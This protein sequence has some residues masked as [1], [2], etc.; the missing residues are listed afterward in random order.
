[1]ATSLNRINS[2]GHLLVRCLNPDDFQ[3][4]LKAGVTIGTYTGVDEDEVEAP[5][6]QNQ[7]LDTKV[8]GVAIKDGTTKVLEH[9]QALYEAALPSCEGNA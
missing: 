5:E 7:V 2:E 3:L 6:C 8:A 4:S 1:M 9:L